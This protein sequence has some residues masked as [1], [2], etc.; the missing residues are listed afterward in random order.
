MDERELSNVPVDPAL[1][2][3]LSVG[4][5]ERIR[6][7]PDADQ[8]DSFELA[9]FTLKEILPDG[10]IRTGL[11]MAVIERMACLGRLMNDERMRGWIRKI[12]YTKTVDIDDSLF[13]ATATCPMPFDG[14]RFNFDA[15][16]FFAL[17]LACQQPKGTQ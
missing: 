4:M 10:A 5:S 3:E 8:L 7:D 1:I 2:K 14:K 13:E 17:A 12:P 9:A 15:D 6:H 16:E 11:A